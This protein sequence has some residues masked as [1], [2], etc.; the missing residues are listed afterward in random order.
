MICD[1][2]GFML[3][4]KTRITVAKEAYNTALSNSWNAVAKKMESIYEEF[5]S[6][7]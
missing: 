7:E 2:I 1:K 4:S 3:D 6:Y 5:F